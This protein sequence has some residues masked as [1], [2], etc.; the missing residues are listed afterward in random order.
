MNAREELFGRLREILG[1]EGNSL[2]GAARRDPPAPAAAEGEADAVLL[3]TARAEQAGT[4]VRDFGGGRAAAEWLAAH[5]ADAGVRKLWLG[6]LARFGLDIGLVERAA[7][8]KGIEVMRAERGTGAGT[9]ARAFLASCDLAVTVSSFAC[10]DS[11]VVAV[12]SGPDEPR[13][14]SLLPSAHAA[15]L[16]RTDIYPDLASALA[17]RGG[18]RPAALTLIGGPSRTADIEKVLVT[19]VHGPKRFIVCIV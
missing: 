5:I 10:A 17:S 4:E 12:E 9:G 19:G 1:D 7:A 18:A 15:I 2:A 8:E 16:R 14:A 6:D 11:G 13:A 3:F